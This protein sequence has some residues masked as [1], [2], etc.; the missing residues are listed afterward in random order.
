MRGGGGSLRGW[1]FD[2]SL[3]YKSQGRLPNTEEMGV[4]SEEN[5]PEICTPQEQDT[6]VVTSSPELKD[7]YFDIC[8]K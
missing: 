2:P 4:G 5:G 1:I 3:K 6:T 7:L 8:H